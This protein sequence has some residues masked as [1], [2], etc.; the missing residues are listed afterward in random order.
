MISVRWTLPLMLL[1][2]G[3]SGGP[4]VPASKASPAIGKAVQTQSKTLA[5][6]VP[7]GWEAVDPLNPAFMR[8]LTQNGNQNLEARFLESA[9]SSDLMVM[10]TKSPDPKFL[11]SI[12]IVSAGSA[13]IKTVDDLETIFRAME[14][15]FAPTK[16]EHSLV[17]FPIGPTVCVWGAIDQNG[18]QS[19]LIAYAFSAK[20]KGYVVSFATKRGNRDRFRGLT[21]SVMQT[22]VAD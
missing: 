16:L 11:E 17:G 18:A 21:E 14:K 7:A 8:A 12:N 4:P 6:T 2:I 13:D 9:N 20:G 15:Q 5:L 3:C 10:N 1:P 22:I 19:D